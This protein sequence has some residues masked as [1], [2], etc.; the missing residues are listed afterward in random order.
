[1]EIWKPIPQWEKYSI[2]SFGNIRVEKTGKLLAHTKRKGYHGC[3]LYNNGKY[4]IIRIHAYM[5][6]TFTNNWDMTLQAAHLDGNKNNNNLDN[7]KLVTC[8]EN[9]AHKRLHGT[10]CIGEKQGAS[11]LTEKK[12]IEIKKLLKRKT[13]KWGDWS[14]LRIAKLYN[15]SPTLIWNIDHNR[16]WTHIQLSTSTTQ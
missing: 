10:L 6:R 2:S 14:N 13:R 12:V 7:I 5:V 3:M 11:K 1:M 16:A 15:V 4:K 9:N 8:K